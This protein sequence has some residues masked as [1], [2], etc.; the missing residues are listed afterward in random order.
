M[1]NTMRLSVTDIKLFKSLLELIQ[2]VMS[3]ELIADEFKEPY[4]ARLE[5]IVDEFRPK[6]NGQ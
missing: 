4:V 6:Y 3:D 1:N 5:N 2:D